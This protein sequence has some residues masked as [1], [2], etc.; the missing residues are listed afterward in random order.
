MTLMMGVIDTRHLLD[1]TQWDVILLSIII[2]G[3]IHKRN[4]IM[5]NFPS[6]LEVLKLETYDGTEDP[7][8]HDEHEDNVLDYHLD[9]SVMMCKLFILTL[10]GATCWCKP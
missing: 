6:L 10:R 7:D 9:R 8:E 1:I 2:D 3:T 4:Q 5:H